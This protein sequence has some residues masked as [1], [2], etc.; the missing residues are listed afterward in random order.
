MA[1]E[2]ND[3]DKVSLDGL[4]RTVMTVRETDPEMPAQTL[5]ALLEIVKNPGITMIELQNKLNMSSAGTSRVVS[6]LSQI[7]KPNVP[8][9]DFVLRSENLMDR[10]NKIVQPTPKGLAFVRKLLRKL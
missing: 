6:R 7:E 5:Y 10:R 9:L 4:I 1:L 3:D 8:G 2:L